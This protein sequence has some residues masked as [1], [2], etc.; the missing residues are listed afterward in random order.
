MKKK[1]EG[2][3]LCLQTT[4]Y[5][6][7]RKNPSPL[8]HFLAVAVRAPPISCTLRLYQLYFALRFKVKKIKIQVKTGCVASEW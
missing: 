2:V 6:V 5:T 3:W 8:A 7:R 4:G 1:K